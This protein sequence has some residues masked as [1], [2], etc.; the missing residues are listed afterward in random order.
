MGGPVVDVT[1]GTTATDVPLG[2]RVWDV[3]ADGS[4]QGLVTR[5]IYR[6]D[7]APGPGRTARFQ[8]S[9]QGYRFA[10]GHRMKVEVT[11][12]DAPYHQVSSLPAT[13]TVDRLS[14]TLPV[15]GRAARMPRTSART[16][17]APSPGRTWPWWVASGVTVL[18]IG[19]VLVLRRGSS[20]ASAPRG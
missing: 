17:A 8:I 5:G 10:A 19:I 14:L 6:V 16:V 13:V 1:F 20:R 15:L 7:G 2:V 12:I 4:V 9:D 18:A 11:A 3:T